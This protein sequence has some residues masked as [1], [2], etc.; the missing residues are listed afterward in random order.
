MPRGGF[1]KEPM[2]TLD[3]HATLTLVTG[4]NAMLRSK[5]IARWIELE[6][7]NGANI[8]APAPS[9][10]HAQPVY[11]AQPHQ[12]TRLSFNYRESAVE[13]VL[14]ANNAPLFNADD[15][16]AAL[17][18]ARSHGAYHWLRCH[19]ATMRTFPAAGEGKRV[20]R[21][22]FPLELLYLFL[23]HSGKIEKFRFIR[24]L[25]E[26]VLPDLP[27]VELTPPPCS[28]DNLLPFQDRTAGACFLL[29]FDE[30]QQP[31]LSRL[32][33]RENANI[34]FYDVP[35]APNFKTTTYYPIDLMLEKVRLNAMASGP[36][37]K[38]IT[39]TGVV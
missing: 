16:F 30:Q 15:I 3:F 8:P 28:L 12:P 25:E 7:E 34:T 23:R 10:S 14:D 36:D 37:R 9:P 27:K 26:R 33:A 1:R 5:V 32:A 24:W 20:E 6:N 2:Y 18:Y 29:T 21:K 4:Y 22:Y 19:A 31:S 38:N 17:G 13:V 11:P 35:G 39:V